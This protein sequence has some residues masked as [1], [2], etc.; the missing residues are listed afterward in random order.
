MFF[1]V[2]HKKSKYRYKNKNFFPAITANAI[3]KGSIEGSNT[4]S[5]YFGQTYGEDLSEQQGKPASKVTFGDKVFLINSVSDLSNV[6]TSFSQEDIIDYYS[7]FFESSSIKVF[8]IVNI[9]Y[10]IRRL[11]SKQAVK[12]LPRSIDVL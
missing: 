7:K 12:N 3:L 1:A 2:R 5:I 11:V 10:I 9:V 4:Y 8:A 6:P